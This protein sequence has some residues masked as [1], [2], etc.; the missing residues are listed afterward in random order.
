MIFY[1]FRYSN[2]TDLLDMCAY[3]DPRTKSMPYLNDEERKNVHKK[4]FNMCVQDCNSRQVDDRND[5]PAS[6]S[7]ST[8]SENPTEGML[9]S[10]LG[11]IY[12]GTGNTSANEDQVDDSTNTADIIDFE[13]KRYNSAA[14]LKMEG[15]PLQW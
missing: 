12:S 7:L 15:N 1:V 3:L 2:D 8:S 9:V 11:D 13:M 5:T 6:P 14:S 10:L 4:V